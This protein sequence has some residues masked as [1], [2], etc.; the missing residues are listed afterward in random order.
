MWVASQMLVQLF[1]R[2][3]DTN[4]QTNRQAKYVHKE[5]AENSGIG[6]RLLDLNYDSK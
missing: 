1:A 6:G 4:G 5:E 3:L 2:L